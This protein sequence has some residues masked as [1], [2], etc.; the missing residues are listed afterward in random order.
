MITINKL[1]N[2]YNYD[3]YNLIIFILIVLSIIIGVYMNIITRFI[4]WL[5]K[6]F[7]I[8][9]ADEPS[10]PPRSNEYQKKNFMT[11][12]EYDFYLKLLDLEGEFRVIPQINLATIIKK[13]NGGYINELFKNI[14][15]AIFDKD[16]KNVLL[17]IELNDSSHGNQDRK[18]RDMKVKKIC[19]EA[20]IRLVTFYTSYPNEKEYVINR[21][22]K[23][24][25]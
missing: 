18:I 21:I 11:N 4:K 14:D 5:I 6:I 20:G 19:E 8:D 7:G 13:T 22:K 24:I 23:N 12:C 1:I 10:S 9:M 17:L 15:F 3:F 25:N 16:F 2:F